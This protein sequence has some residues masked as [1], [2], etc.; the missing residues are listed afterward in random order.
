MKRKFAVIDA[1]HEEIFAVAARWENSEKAV[2]EGFYRSRLSLRHDERGAGPYP[3]ADQIRTALQGLSR[4]TG[5][6]V[7]DVYAGISSPSVNVLTSYGSMV[8]SKYGREV[9][10]RDIKRCVEAGSIARIPIDKE[11]LHRI[12]LGFSID[13]E[14][15]ISD[16]EGLEAV[17]LGVE[18]N[19]VTINTT[20]IRNFSKNIVHA[21]YAP[22]GFV[23]APLATALRMLPE[24]DITGNTAFIFEGGKR[25]EIIFFGAGNL[26]NCKIFDRPLLGGDRAEKGEGED[27]G[28]GWFFK[29]IP[30]MRGWQKIKKIVIA[31]SRAPSERFLQS[32][33]KILGLPVRVG[34]PSARSFEDL[35]EDGASYATALGILDHLGNERRKLSC[36]K[37]PVKKALK[38]LACLLDGYF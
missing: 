18:I 35:P 24:E 31:G 22:S 34:T 32:I 11:V 15:M 37:N 23:L 30:T 4:K 3:D 29:Y 8:V 17:K 5:I 12:V 28:Y 7:H 36:E 25:T 13:G 33:E 16:P 19:M 6:P 14:S 26:E 21:G 27:S 9:T 2:P 10:S 38:R 20:A 1:G